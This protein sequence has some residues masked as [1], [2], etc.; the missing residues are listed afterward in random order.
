MERTTGVV[1]RPGSP[2]DIEAVLAVLHAADMARSGGVIGFMDDPDRARRR[3]ASDG[4]LFVVA[5]AGR[6]LIGVAAGL[7]ARTDGGA[8]VAIDGLCHIT[9]VAVRPERWGQGIGGGLVR[10][11]ISAVA[12]H[13]YVRAQLFTQVDNARAQRLYTGLGFT[14]SGETH[15]SAAGEAIMHYEIALLPGAAEQPYDMKRP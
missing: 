5:M 1:I 10:A 11:L 15:V 2:A 14:P 12:T 13:G 6:E 3:F 9:M 4:A 8:G 7:Q